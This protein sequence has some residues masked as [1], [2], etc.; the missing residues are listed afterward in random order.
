MRKHAMSDAEFGQ[1]ARA[2]STANRAL[3]RGDIIP[4]ACVECGR[5]NAEMHHP[6]H[7][8]P[9]AVVWMCRRCHANEHVVERRVGTMRLNAYLRGAVKRLKTATRKRAQ[10]APQAQP[11]L[12]L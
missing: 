4:E 7:Q 11:E 1:R 5:E 10:P 12:S 3:L 9:L 2:R 6:D 8:R